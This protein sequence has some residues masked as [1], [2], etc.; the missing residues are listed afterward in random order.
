[1]AVF[2]EGVC[3]VYHTFRGTALVPD[4]NE[5]F[6]MSEQHY[7]PAVTL[8]NFRYYEGAALSSAEL[9]AEVSSR[10]V[11]SCGDGMRHDLEACDDG[12]SDSGDGCSSDCEVEAGYVCGGSNFT[13]VST[14]VCRP[15][16][17]WLRAEFEP[18]ADSAPALPCVG[19]VDDG[20]STSN[21]DTYP[22]TDMNL[23]QFHLQLR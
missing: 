11:Q 1:M 16:T 21:L 20:A 4:G 13:A 8:S 9:R 6:W 5:N 17:V 23:G 19:V 2:I 15:G 10:N 7:P 22:G 12:N 14:D 3:Q 18:P